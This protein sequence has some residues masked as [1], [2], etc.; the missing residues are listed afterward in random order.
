MKSKLSLLYLIA[1]TLGVIGFIAFF[2]RWPQPFLSLFILALPFYF[3]SLTFT[4]L[5]HPIICLAYLIKKVKRKQKIGIIITHLIWSL[6]VAGVFIGM[7]MNG[8]IITV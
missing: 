7:V 4:I 1:G 2:E 5:I 8:F 3:A 6:I